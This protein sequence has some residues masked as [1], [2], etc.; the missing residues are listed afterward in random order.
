MS[1][2]RQDK[3]KNKK[4]GTVIKIVLAVLVIII[5][6]LVHRCT[7]LFGGK[8]KDT[9]RIVTEYEM[10]LDA[11]TEMDPE[12][13][14]EAVNIAVEEGMMNVNY[15]ANARFKGKVSEA[16]NIRNI[17]NNHGPILFE[18]FDEEGECVYASKKIAPGYEMNRIELTKSLKK[19]THEGTIKVR[20][21]DQGSVS[22][23]F[24]ITIEVK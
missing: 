13:R 4:R 14:Q 17:E 12:E 9:T 24:P 22:A 21:A 8:D 5:L 10:D 19:G 23:V 6:L 16:F 1:E 2:N 7:N 11:I 18:L 15:S 3:Q 20:Y